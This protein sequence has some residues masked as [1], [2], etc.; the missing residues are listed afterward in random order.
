MAK[1]REALD[2]KY[3]WDLNSLYPSDEAWEEDFK[4]ISNSLHEYESFKGHVL[5]DVETLKTII[6]KISE[7][8]RTI[9]NLMTYAKMKSDENTKVSH[10]QSFTARVEGLIGQYRE[11]TSFLIP[12]L[13]QGDE[14]HVQ[15]LIKDESLSMYQQ[16]I[17]NIL[18]ARPHTLSQE[19]ENLLAQ[20]S[21]MMSTPSNAFG[22]LSGADLKFPSVQKGDEEVDLSHGSFVPLLMEKDRDLRAQVYQKYYGVYED[23]KNVFASLLSSEVKKNIFNAKARKHPSARASALFENNI[24]ETVYDNLINAVHSNLDALHEYISLRKEMLGVDTLRPYDLYVP[25]IDNVDMTFD[26]EKA[27]ETVLTS[28]EVLGK[29]YVSVVENSFKDGW[30]DVYENEGKRSGAYSWGTYDSKPYILLNYHNKLSD[31]FTLTHEMGHSMHSY[32]TR[33]CQPFVYGHYSIFVAEVASTTNEALLN[34]HLLNKVKDKK[35][36][37]YLLN[38][39]LEN[40]RGTVFRQTMFAE[41]ERE[42][43]SMVESGKALTSE[44]LSDIYRALNEKYY[45]KDLEVDDQLALEWA[46]IPHFYYN[47]YV[48]QYATG[49][50][51]AEALANKIVEEGKPA[52]EAYFDFLGAGCSDYPIEVLKKAGVDMTTPEPVD[53]ALDTFRSLVKEMKSLLAE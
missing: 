37:L 5:D 25:L 42:I 8:S 12:E 40:F 51:S 4:N 9:S 2:P 1:K 41:F 11:A 34:K 43:H 22:M 20:A 3:Q 33:K 14:A 13:I 18:R 23:H 48:F 10:Y 45:G 16:H 6:E 39:Y 24:P 46:R 38:N 27:K 32:Y 36:K 47:F 44:T 31:M 35:E 29:D 53:Q 50:S 52:I 19:A 30:I 28:L 17:D 15:K 7:G 21:E 49:F 26:Y